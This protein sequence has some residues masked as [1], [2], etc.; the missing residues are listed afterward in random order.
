MN[1]YGNKKT[2]MYGIRF[3]SKKEADRYLILRSEM[4]RGAIQDLILQPKFILQCA[5]TDAMGEKHRQIEYWGDF[6]YFDKKKKCM[7]VEDVK[8]MQTEV[9]KLKKKLFLY[10]Y[11]DILFLEV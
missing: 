3:D 11:Q 10:S 7:V 2:T 9:Y 6:Q 4:N 1:K 8:G 5:F